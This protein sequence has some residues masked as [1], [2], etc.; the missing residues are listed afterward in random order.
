MKTN[1]ELNLGEILKGHEGESFYSHSYGK[2]IFLK[3]C[4]HRL[5]FFKQRHSKYIDRT[6]F[7][8]SFGGR[9]HGDG[10]IDIFP[11]KN[12][13]DWNKWINNQNR[14]ISNACN[15]L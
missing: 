7:S 8:V 12:N 4:G 14:K 10:E 1:K 5:I 13:R 15:T 6:E 2:V 9:I 11:S 3:I